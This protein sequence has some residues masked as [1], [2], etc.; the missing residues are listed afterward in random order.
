MGLFLRLAE[1][2]QL[3]R[4]LKSYVELA[5]LGMVRSACARTAFDAA[6]G[7]LLD[8]AALEASRATISVPADKRGGLGLR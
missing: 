8:D 1:Y 5:E 2:R 7:S 6:F 4:E 3:A